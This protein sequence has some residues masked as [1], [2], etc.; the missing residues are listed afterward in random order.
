MS[1]CH[2][3]VIGRIDRLVIVLFVPV[4][5]QPICIELMVD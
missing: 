3:L 2:L 5:T 1:D 4:H